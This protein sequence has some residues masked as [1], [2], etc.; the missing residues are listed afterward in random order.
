[1]IAYVS[2]KGEDA[3]DF[4]LR[5]HKLHAQ[6]RSSKEINNAHLSSMK[7]SKLSC[8]DSLQSVERTVFR[9]DIKIINILNINE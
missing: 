5:R 8:S 2:V 3:F 6:R 4:T 7:S 9:Y 1:M